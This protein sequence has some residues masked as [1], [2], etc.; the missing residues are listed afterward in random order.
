M[1]FSSR[2]DYNSYRRRW[3]ARRR[4]HGSPGGAALA[5]GSLI[6]AVRSSGQPV[7]SSVDQRAQVL[8]GS[9]AASFPF[10][11][12]AFSPG[13]ECLRLQFLATRPAAR[14][15]AG[16]RPGLAPL[17]L[18]LGV[19]ALVLW[20]I[21]SRKASAVVDAPHIVDELP[22]WKQWIPKTWEG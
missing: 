7:P 3:R 2:A 19:G 8:A 4:S 11:G 18:L 17:L 21:F 5:P 20:F 22:R 9:L 10:S 15:S 6:G 13:P 16:S 1:P 12:T 14:P